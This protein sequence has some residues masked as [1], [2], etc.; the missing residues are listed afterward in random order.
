LGIIPI[1]DSRGSRYEPFTLDAFSVKE[2]A[3]LCVLK[4]LEMADIATRFERDIVIV[5]GAMGTMLLAE[6]IDSETH[7]MLV[8]VFD[9]EVVEA[10]HK[11]YI[12]AGA[13]AITTNSFSGSRVALARYGLETRLEELNRAAVRLAKSC[14]PEHV[15]ADVGPCGL[16]MAP[17]GE[18]SFD[19]VFAIYAEQISVLSSEAP[20]AI[21]IE[22]M[23]DIA[24]ARVA[25]LAAKS[26]CDLPVFVTLSFNE[27]GV[28]PLS[29]TDASTAAFILQKAGADVV[30]MNCSLGFAAMLPLLEQMAGACDLPLMVQPNAGVP[31]V[32]RNG[33]VVYDGTPDQMAE[34]AWAYRQLGAQFIGSCC[35]STP[36]HTAAIFAAVGYSDVVLTGRGSSA[37]GSSDSASPTMLLASPRSTVK[38]AFD[39]PCRVIGERINLTN[40][41]ILTAELATAVTTLA[42][43]MAI[44]QAD[45][46][47]DLIDINIAGSAVDTVKMLPALV[48]ELS[49]VVKAP[50]VLDSMNIQA[51]EAALKVYAGRALI[52]S[53]NASESSLEKVLPL[54]AK[55]GA[56]VVAMCTDGRTLP[57]NMDE[58]MALA[59]RILASAAE[60]GLT[61]NDI[62]FD[63]LTLAAVENETA[64]ADAATVAQTLTQRGL[65]S[66]AAISNISFKLENRSRLEAD[67]VS[68]IVKAGVTAV[69]LNPNNKQV[70][71]A[72][73]QANKRSFTTRDA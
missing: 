63:V 43:N 48:L 29:A 12:L 26:V 45:A 49:S 40:K 7:P 53:V 22:T 2:I 71:T 41:P 72:F 10:I 39:E 5:D 31:S 20:D 60:Y 9:P 13:Q 3:V 68:E 51:L 19:E 66:V 32:A 6:G 69:I 4:E 36:A 57:A 44:E 46:G 30:G 59:D 70:M 62:L 50:L 34:A 52:N 21:L 33:E 16:L 38:L 67:Y 54:A 8:N 55:Y 25:V 15:L 73:N 35:G 42:S 65:L 18:A 56:A 14:R 1:P 11:R 17:F 23:T 47:A 61:R 58:R 64:A 37:R 27:G 24:D 28:M